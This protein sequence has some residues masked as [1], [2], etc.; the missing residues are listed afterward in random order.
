[1]R[2]PGL[3]TVAQ[4]PTPRGPTIP[5]IGLAEAY[6]LASFRQAGVPMQRIRPAIRRF[7]EEIG[8]IKR[9]PASDFALMAPKCCGITVSRRTTMRKRRQSAILSWYATASWFSGQ[10]YRII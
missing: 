4:A 9:W 10:S 2:H 7:E 1:M 6:V 8:L 3:I 5:F